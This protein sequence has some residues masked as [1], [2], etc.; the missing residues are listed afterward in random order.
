MQ[1]SYVFKAFMCGGYLHEKKNNISEQKG[2]PINVSQ[3]KI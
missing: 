3:K 2:G 1:F